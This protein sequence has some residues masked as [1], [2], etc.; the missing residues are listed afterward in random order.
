MSSN[1]RSSSEA[2]S[3]QTRLLESPEQN[4]SQ[5]DAKFNHF[6]VT[7][8]VGYV[9][10]II[11]LLSF[12]YSNQGPFFVT[13]ESQIVFW[14]IY[15]ISLISSTV[16]RIR[17]TKNAVLFVKH[18]ILGCFMTIIYFL[19]FITYL[20]EHMRSLNP[21]KRPVDLSRW[22]WII[23]GLVLCGSIESHAYCIKNSNDILVAVLMTIT[24]VVILCPIPLF[25]SH[26]GFLFP[27]KWLIS[28]PN[29]FVISLMT[30]SAITLYQ[31]SSFEMA[32]YWKK[33]FIVA[34]L[35]SFCFTSCVGAPAFLSAFTKHIKGSDNLPKGFW[36]AIAA[37]ADALAILETM[38]PGALYRIYRGI[39]D[40][41]WNSKP[42][43]EEQMEEV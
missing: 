39:K 9:Y 21:P 12:Y 22:M 20:Q 23:I 25:L 8:A 34:S 6:F 16:L 35:K 10:A 5:S 14:G 28:S 40:P 29:F 17:L 24:Y 38:Y 43:D 41:L 31:T 32:L 2:P 30:F 27:L 13:T 15:S 18:W 26:M 36:Y 42:T 33:R 4:P 37:T 19:I 1:S 7:I 3:E 11:N